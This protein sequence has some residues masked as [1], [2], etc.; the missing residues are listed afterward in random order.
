MEWRG[1]IAFRGL[2]IRLDMVLGIIKVR[3]QKLTKDLLTRVRVVV[4]YLT[5]S[6]DNSQVGNESDR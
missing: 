4:R 6:K 2:G 5:R 3:R 1:W